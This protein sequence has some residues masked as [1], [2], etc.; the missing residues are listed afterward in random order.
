MEA[1]TIRVTSFVLVSFDTP[2]T[3]TVF[4]HISAHVFVDYDHSHYAVARVAL[5]KALVNNF[6]LVVA[7]GP[8][9]PMILICADQPT[10]LP[11]SGVKRV[12]G[13]EQELPRGHAA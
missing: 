11:R 1:Y 2:P 3:R 12:A 8:S 10:R 13:F 7:S 9:S 5:T 4:S 6:G